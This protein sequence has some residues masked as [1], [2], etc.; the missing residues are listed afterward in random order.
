MV[1]PEELTA[2]HVKHGAG[3]AWSEGLPELAAGYLERWELTLDGGP[4]HGIVSL[5]LPVVRADGTA[6]VLKLQPLDDESAGEADGLRAWDGDGSVR[7]LDDDPSTGTM[8]LERLDAARPLSVVADHMKATFVLAELLS[9]LVAVPAPAG[10]RRLGDIASAMLEQVPMAHRGLPEADDRRLLDRCASA[11]RDLVAEPGDRLLHWDLHFDNVLA[12]DREPWLAID[13]KP[14]VGDPGF[15]LMP[16]LDN[17]WD[18]IVATGDVT[19]AVRERFDL[20]TEVL[21]LDRR[22]A[23]GWT[24]GRALQNILWDVEDGESRVS[25]VQRA[26]AEA[27]A[28][29]Y[30]GR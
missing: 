13:P 7:L 26:V 24:L 30:D 20:M 29:E 27:L 17:R 19:R 21:G 22:R 15:D 5:V 16:A 6:A 9:R 12:S 3:L 28:S 18:D 8:L 1:V 2:L 10:L 25:P 14:L 11:V 23:A 4:M